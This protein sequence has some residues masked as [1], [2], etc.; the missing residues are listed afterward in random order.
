[1]AQRYLSGDLDE[2]EWAAFEERI[3]VDADLQAALVEMVK[4]STGISQVQR[5]PTANRLEGQTSPA[6]PVAAARFRQALLTAAV[7]SVGAL[8]LLLRLALPVSDQLAQTDNDAAER[9]VA[10]ADVPSVV[11]LWS[12]L[13][14]ETFS[15]DESFSPLDEFPREVDR[16]DEIHV[17]HWLLVAVREESNRRVIESIR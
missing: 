2:V 17:P 5:R 8:G 3:A 1:L 10:A 11:A 12:S 13:G 7:L 6:P 14:T 4:L 9:F 16:D 15:E